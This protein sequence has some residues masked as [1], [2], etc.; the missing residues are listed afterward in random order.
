MKKLQF[1]ST[2]PDT[3]FG[4]SFL[5]ISPQH[6]LAIDLAKENIEM[7]EFFLRNAKR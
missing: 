3:I 2:R 4:A 5:A 1:F 6:K 7:T